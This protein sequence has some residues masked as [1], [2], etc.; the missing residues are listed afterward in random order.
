MRDR[1]SH[2][3]IFSPTPRVGQKALLGFLTHKMLNLHS[4]SNSS[5]TA[6]ATSSCSCLYANRT[7]R[8]KGGLNTT[9]FC[10]GDTLGVLPEKKLPIFAARGRPCPVAE[11]E[12]QCQKNKWKR[13]CSPQVCSAQQ[14][15]RRAATMYKTPKRARNPRSTSTGSHSTLRV[16][17]NNTERVR[18]GAA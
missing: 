3:A 10:L 4:S 13:N 16:M 5:L 1:W 8:N 12:H 14:C 9:R 18:R 15:L 17:G 2:F 7:L 11:E 6:H